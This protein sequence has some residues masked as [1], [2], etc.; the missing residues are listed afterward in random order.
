VQ[1][2]GVLV[3][4]QHIADFGP[5]LPVESLFFNR[6]V[7]GIHSE[8]AQEIFRMGE[9]TNFLEKIEEIDDNATISLPLGGGRVLSGPCFTFSPAQPKTSNDSRSGVRTMGGYPGSGDGGAEAIKKGPGGFIPEETTFGHRRGDG[10]EKGD[11]IGG[12]AR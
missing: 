3:A 12:I 4:F 6:E 1:K 2:F 5:S 9:R 11:V 10:G 8:R 7:K